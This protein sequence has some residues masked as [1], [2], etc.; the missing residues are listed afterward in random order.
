MNG[1]KQAVK[2][3][4]D[5]KE[6]ATVNSS[7]KVTA[8]EAGIAKITA[9]VGGAKYVCRV[10]VKATPIPEI[11]VNKEKLELKI[12]KSETLKVISYS[13]NVIKNKNIIWKSS[14]TSVATVVD[15]KITALTGIK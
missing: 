10:K 3:S 13:G 12:G 7:G 2:W 5:D 8:K 1:T 6:V 11:K 15:G 4:S 9:N 14:D